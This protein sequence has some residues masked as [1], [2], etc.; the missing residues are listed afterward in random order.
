MAILITI[1]IATVSGLVSGG[2]LSW[3]V[4]GK[5]TGLFDD[6]EF[7]VDC[8]HKFDKDTEMQGDD[9]V[10]KHLLDKEENK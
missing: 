5:K 9:E 4:W 6:E 1:G 7:W 3:N 10:S 2:L 8:E